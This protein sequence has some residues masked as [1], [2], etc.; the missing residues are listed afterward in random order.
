MRTSAL[1]LFIPLVLLLAACG[2]KSGSK[3]P[4]SPANCQGCCD[5]VA[6]A[7]QPGLSTNACGT[8]GLACTA[9]TGLQQCFG[10]IC[11]N[12]GGGGGGGGSGSDAGR[13]CELTGCDGGFVW[14]DGAS[15]DCRPGCG[16]AAQCPIQGVCDL[17]THTCG[18]GSGRHPC[19]GKCS[20]NT[21]VNSCGSSCTPC[22]APPNATATCNGVS[23]GSTC[24]TGFHLCAGNCASNSS[25]G[26]CGSSCSPCTAPPNATPSC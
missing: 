1:R 18:C 6:G 13:G 23:C 5:P 12:S 10:G 9:C 3:P 16:T 4:C 14:C 11:L 22:T 20:D 17:Q 7:C 25:I 15:G 8:S 19:N 2:G 21:N 26:S 24:N